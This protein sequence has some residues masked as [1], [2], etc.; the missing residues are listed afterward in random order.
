VNDAGDDRARVGEEP[1]ARGRAGHE[2]E[3][4]TI[5]ARLGREAPIPGSASP[6]P[7]AFFL[8]FAA[9]TA[10]GSMR[11]SIR[12]PRMSYLA[13]LAAQGVGNHT[14]DSGARC[15]LGPSRT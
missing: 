12:Q 3:P 4:G 1:R 14:Y 15:L 8:A 10:T 11:S 6:P 2:G 9:G 13:W 7:G 5:R